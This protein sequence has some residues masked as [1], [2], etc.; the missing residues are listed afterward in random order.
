M[1][2]HKVSSVG[3]GVHHARMRVYTVLEQALP[4][5]QVSRFVHAALILLALALSFKMVNWAA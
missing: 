4:D 3:R 1:N 2:T 5:D